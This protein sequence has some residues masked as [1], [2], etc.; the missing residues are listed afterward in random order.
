MNKNKRHEFEEI[1]ADKL[2]SEENIVEVSLEKRIFRG[3]KIFLA[4]GIMAVIAQFFYLI[5]AKGQ[6]YQ[7]AALD[8]QDQKIYTSAPR[9]II[10]DHFGIPLVQNSII[11]KISKSQIKMK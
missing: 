5:L 3:V 9:G 4:L 10:Y 6:T 2:G 8:N 7:G 1:F 11:Q